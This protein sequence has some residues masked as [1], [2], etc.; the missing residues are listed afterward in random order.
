MELSDNFKTHCQACRTGPD[1]AKCSRL[2]IHFGKLVIL[3]K[4]EGCSL[5]NL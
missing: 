4:L 5:K 3:E 2:S 1:Y